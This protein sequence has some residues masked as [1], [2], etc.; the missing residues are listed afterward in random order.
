M[1]NKQHSARYL[2]VVCC[3]LIGL[4]IPAHAQ[5]DGQLR[6]TVFSRWFVA[7]YNR[8][9]IP[10][11][12]LSYNQ[13]LGQIPEARELLEQQVFFS[14][15]KDRLAESSYDN[16]SDNDKIDYQLAA[17]EIK[18]NLE[19]LRLSKNLV[20]NRPENNHTAG[21]FHIP[22][23]KQWYA[24]FLNRWLGAEVDPDEIF[25]F[26]L[27]QINRA[28]L[29][30][31]QLRQSIGLSPENFKQQLRN[32]EFF[33][34]DQSEI[35]ANFEAIREIVS[36]N[37]AQQFF[38]YPDIPM[39]EIARG[40]NQALSQVPG[41]YDGQTFYFNLFDTP[42]NKRA[43]DWLYLHEAVPGHHFQN[44]I[45]QSQDHS[46]M[47]R[48]V[49]YYGFSEGW[50]AYVES[51]G[52][53]LG[54][55]DNPYQQLGRWEWDIVRSVR[56]ALDVGIN[57]YGWPDQ[58]ALLFWQQHITDR[59]DIG[60]REVQRMRRWPAQVITYKYGAAQIEN[61]KSRLLLENPSSFSILRFHDYLL[62][63]GPLPFDLLEQLVIASDSG[64]CKPV[65]TTKAINQN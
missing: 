56:V 7:E 60:V 29:N 8:L 41:Y 58:Q 39:V 34:S 30:I 45:E 14:T 44:F 51:L 13:N 12:A 23:G 37:L 25:E 1:I 9:D 5:P 28:K 40:K 46:A 27:Q 31:E 53:E 61:W 38:V 2:A 33:T 3:W 18:Q 62:T 21:I 63:L 22:E 17:F 47:R 35:Q 65:I 19:R 57:Y 42:Y 36:D 32:V 55:Y 24:Y 20:G 15:A 50:A 11:L 52:Q 64:I 54:L 48:L 43:S 49:R 59:D 6:F 16:L 26:G 4:L 10:A